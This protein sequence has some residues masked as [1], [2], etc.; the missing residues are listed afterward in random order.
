MPEL[1]EDMM[2]QSKRPRGY[3]IFL[4]VIL[5]FS[6]YLSYLILFPFLDTL[7]LAIV[8]ATL[9]Q[10]LQVILERK[11]KGRKNLA[12]LIIVL[13]I[14]FVI[15]LPVFFFA[16]A[17]VA[18]GLDTVNKVNDWIK[19]GGLQNLVQDPRIND[20]L[21]RLQER[22]T[23]LTLDKTEISNDILTVSK[24]IGQFLL[25]K[26]A[27]IL[28]NMAS[29]IAQFFVMVF[30]AFYLVRDGSEMVEQARHVS[31]LRSHQED[32]IING[33]RVV[34]KSV[35]LGTFLTAILQGIAGGVAVAILGFPGLFWGTMTALSSLIPIVG[36]FLVW[37]PIALYLVL[38]GQTGSA[39][40]LA[41]WS[42][43]LPGIIDN[44]IRPSLMKG[45]SKMS[46]FY[47]FLA[48]LGG[49]QYFGL[50]GILYGPLIL[51]FAMIML[52]IYSV[53]YREDLIEYKR[54][55][56]GDPSGP[57]E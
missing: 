7:I 3:R 42:I 4:L 13:I 18:Q 28:S 43:V 34:A 21:A 14:T 52:Y 8:C 45:K 33:I 11:L 54:G 51:S 40:F 25:G 35:L 53:E 26:V 44:I 12:A 49:V 50:R 39:V 19:T 9:F 46:P 48:I 2:D 20:Y 47:I 41:I 38:L 23:F 37:I 24:N 27:S 16:S 31:P 10:P 55:H 36:T 22:F 17:L 15:A 32:R 30:I 56:E 29:L 1:E 6:F 5:F 57:Q